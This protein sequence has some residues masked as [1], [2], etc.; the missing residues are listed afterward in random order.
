[1][2]CLCETEGV[3]CNVF[4]LDS[5]LN[6]DDKRPWSNPP[7]IY[8]ALNKLDEQT[9]VHNNISSLMNF[10]SLFLCFGL[11]VLYIDTHCHGIFE[12]SSSMNNISLYKLG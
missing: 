3:F 8:K 4:L 1:M 11:N 10:Y 5:S 12:L 9:K 6:M 7:S 2:V